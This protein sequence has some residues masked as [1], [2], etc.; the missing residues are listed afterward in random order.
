MGFGTARI[1][2][3]ATRGRT[4]SERSQHHL[5]I[6]RQVSRLE[7]KMKHLK[8][9]LAIAFVLSAFATVSAMD[10]D[11]QVRLEKLNASEQVA[12]IDFEAH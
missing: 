6:G 9:W 3:G 7:S 8:D 1:S 5:Q 4:G 10:Y 11:D 12:R 2:A